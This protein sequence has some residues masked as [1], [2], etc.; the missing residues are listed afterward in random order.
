[1]SKSLMAMSGRFFCPGLVAVAS[2]LTG[3]RQDTHPDSFA[4][5]WI[6]SRTV[7]WRIVRLPPDV[8]DVSHSRACVAG[9]RVLVRPVRI[10]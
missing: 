8:V 5:P 7:L 10:N 3:S 2:M 1:M 9:P 6:A 4:K